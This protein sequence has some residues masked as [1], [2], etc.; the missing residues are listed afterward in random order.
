MQSMGAEKFK[1]VNYR[2]L[3]SINDN[4]KLTE[5]VNYCQY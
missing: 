1:I 5:T 4:L 2:Q 3:L